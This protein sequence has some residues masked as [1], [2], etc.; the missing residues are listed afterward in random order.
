MSTENDNG[1]WT[2]IDPKKAAVAKEPEVS[3]DLEDEV[4]NTEKVETKTN[5]DNE[6]NYEIVSEDDE[7]DNSE[8]VQEVS[9]KE[10]ISELEGINSKGAEKRIRQLVQQRKEREAQLET[11]SSE[12][13]HSKQQSHMRFLLYI[14]VKMN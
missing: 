3:Y 1:G 9:E 4:E 5:V 12:L 8:N 7:Q 2:S 14:L 6:S 10:Q 13:R 11:M